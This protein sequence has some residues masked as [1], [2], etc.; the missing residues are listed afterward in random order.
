MGKALGPAIFAGSK[1]KHAVTF[2]GESYALTTDQVRRIY[3]SLKKHHDLAKGSIS[4]HNALA[5]L[6]A[7]MRSTNRKGS[8]KGA[9]SACPP[10]RTVSTTHMTAKT[11]NAK[12][13]KPIEWEMRG[14]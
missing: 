6:L 3:E 5:Q 2:T 10:P 9:R 4:R 8:S 7:E 12:C 11:Q 13:V 1:T 14:R